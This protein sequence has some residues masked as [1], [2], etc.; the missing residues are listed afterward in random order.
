MDMPREI[1]NMVADMETIDQSGIK[2]RYV[3]DMVHISIKDFADFIRSADLVE[4]V[5]DNEVREA[6]QAVKYALDNTGILFAD[7]KNTTL[8]GAENMRKYLNT[9]I[10][11]ATAKCDCDGLVE[12]LE[13][14][15]KR[16]DLPNPE[17][18]A[19]WKNC[20][21]WSAHEAQ[22]ALAAYK[23]GDG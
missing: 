17:R 21:K 19:D 7:C 11:A 13:K 6:V 4:K 14:I 20:M 10:R 15:A 23:K 22:Q 1:K 3:G 16:P 18:D 12:A 5:D 2:G 8:S 9:L